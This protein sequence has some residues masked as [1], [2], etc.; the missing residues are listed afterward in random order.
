ME[1]TRDN[2]SIALYRYMCRNIVGTEK[3]VKTV[4]MMSNV[5]DNL[6]CADHWTIITS[7]SHGEGLVMRGSDLDL[8]H[9]CKIA[10]VCEDT[11]IDFKPNITYF[12]IEEE[13]TQ[14]GFPQLCLRYHTGPFVFKNCVEEIKGRFYLSNVTFKQQFINKIYPTIHGPCLSD[15]HGFFDF[16]CCLRC[17]SWVT[18][19][20]QWIIRSNNSWPGND[21]KESIIKHGVLFVPIGVKGSTKE[22]LEWRISF[23]VGEKLLI[24]TFTHTQLQCYALMKIL[25][26]DVIAADVNCRD[27]LCS[28]FLKTLM[29][30][31]SEELPTSI[32]KPAN[33][34]FCFL[35]CFHRLLYCVKFSVC[36]HYFIPENN[37]FEN[38]IKGRARDTL[39][40]KLY[41]LKSYGWQCIIFSDQIPSYH[42]LS[43]YINKEPS[44]LNVSILK[45]LFTFINYNADCFLNP[46]IKLEN[47]VHMVLP[48]LSSKIKYLYLYYMS[49]FCSKSSHF[50]AY[51][52]KFG[53]KSTYKQYNTCVST[54]LQNTQ[55]DA[56]SGWLML[57]SFFYGTKQYNLALDILKYSLSK[58]SPEKL[59]LAANCSS[60][61]REV[62]NLNLFRNMPYDQ[63]SKFMMVNL[64]DIPINS[65]LIPTELMIEVE[66][67]LIPPVVY[68]HALRFLCHY[69]L[70]NTAGC[71][72]S[73]RDLQLT[74]EKDYFIGHAYGKSV[75]YN[76]LGITFQLLGDIES[77]RKAFMQSIQIRPR[78]NQNSAFRRLSLI[79]PRQMRYN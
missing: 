33:L 36:P 8:M 49:K 10:E 6:Q 51:T 62:L 58:C 11:Q 47:R 63:L 34:I 15:K 42:R 78:S 68:V 73:L 79:S 45:K 37:L 25:L 41:I 3:H 59:N 1:E 19:S 38:K 21:V 29:F 50:P 70:M 18:Q 71:C 17:K 66:E 9:V 61:K 56:V 28:Y 46:D 55:H 77:A 54:L 65:I 40:N 67:N 60:F 31:V 53:N 44:C 20:K 13:D 35:R 27:L 4:R 2:A 16:A 69:H 52:N 5:R 39:L 22:E 48:I 14:T 74:I 32:W 26:K 43:T 7:G 76:I 24:Y 57:A 72:N 75:S 23:S 64:L 12:T 30:W